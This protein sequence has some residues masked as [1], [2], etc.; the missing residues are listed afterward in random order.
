MVKKKSHRTLFIYM[1][2]HLIGKL[3]KSASGA[4]YFKYHQTWLDTPNAR[5]ISLSLPL[6][7]EQFSGEVVYNFFDNLLPDNP[8]IR[9]RIQAHFHALTDQPFDLLASI[10]KD[11]VGAIQVIEDENI[12]ITDSM[13]FQ[14]LNESDIASILRNIQNHPLGMLEDNNDFR[15]SIAGAQEKSALLFWEG[16]WNRPLGITP[17]THIFKLPIGYIPKI[18]GNGRF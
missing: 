14:P 17:T 13:S 3:E 9:M 6:M 18:L 5:P 7:G 8:Q 16:K 12:Q 11:C 2:E 1:N 10:G 4:H 15:I